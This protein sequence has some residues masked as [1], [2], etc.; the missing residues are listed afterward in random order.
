MP[1]HDLDAK[2]RLVVEDLLRVFTPALK[3][4]T[5]E[6]EPAT[7]YLLRKASERDERREAE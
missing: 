5:H 2:N 6:T 1:D 3:T 7:I 4:L